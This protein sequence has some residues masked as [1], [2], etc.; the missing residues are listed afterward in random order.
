MALIWLSGPLLASSLNHIFQFSHGPIIS[1]V[2]RFSVEWKPNS[3]SNSVGV[4]LQ[5]S[6]ENNNR[7]LSQMYIN[8]RSLEQRGVVYTTKVK[9]LFFCRCKSCR[10]FDPLLISPPRGDPTFP[11]DFLNLPEKT[12]AGKS[13]FR[14]F[15]E[16]STMNGTQKNF[17]PIFNIKITNGAVA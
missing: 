3:S 15:L 16:P 10:Q 4:C 6:R 9:L 17:A 8:F 13:I 14:S 11:I 12:S 7:V 5:R 1:H 2:S